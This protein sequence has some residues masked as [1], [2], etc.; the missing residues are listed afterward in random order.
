MGSL[1]SKVIFRIMLISISIYSCIGMQL[2]AQISEDILIQNFEQ[3]IAHNPEEH[4]FIHT[5]SDIYS[6]GSL[7][8]FQ[9]YLYNY[10]DASINSDSLFLWLV[11]FK[12]ELIEKY[13]FPIHQGTAAGEIS[14]SHSV[15][16]GEYFL[17][18]FTDAT[19]RSVKPELLSHKILVRDFKI[20]PV[21][22]KLTNLK[23]EYSVGD[24]AELEIIL[25]DSKGKAIKHDII[26]YSLSK[27]GT[28]F[29]YGELT[30]DRHG[31]AILSF[32]IPEE[33]GL[34]NIAAQISASYNG[35]IHTNSILIPTI[36]RSILMSFYPEGGKLVEGFESKMVFTAQNV[37]GE[38][39]D[40]EGILIDDDEQ[41]VGIIKTSIPGLGYFS[42]LPDVGNP[43]IMRLTSPVT[44]DF[45]FDFPAIHEEGIQLKMLNISKEE[46]EIVVNSNYEN[47]KIAIMALAEMN[48]GIVWT[49]SAMLEDSLHFI[50]PLSNLPDGI[51]RVNIL[52]QDYKLYAQR[53]LL[54]SKHSGRIDAEM[55]IPERNLLKKGKLILD[56]KSSDNQANKGRVSVSVVD[57]NF[58]PDWSPNP[59]IYTRFLLGPSADNTIF[60]KDYFL[61]REDY[62]PGLFDL[63]MITQIDT[64]YDWQKIGLGNYG[65]ENISPTIFLQRILDNEKGSPM[66]Q[67][68]SI[69]RVDQ[70]NERYLFRDQ[71]AF[72]DFLKVNN[73]KL[74]ERKLTYSQLSKEEKVMKLIA[75]GTP[76][77]SVLRVL[78][79]VIINGGSI[80][81][82]A[83]TSINYNPPALIIVDGVPKGSQSKI[84]KDLNPL[85]VYNMKVYTSVSDILKYT[86]T[87]NS[88]G[89][90]VVTTK[91]AAQALGMMTDKVQKPHDPCLFW[92]PDIELNSGLRIS[93]LIPYPTFKS[94][95]RLVIQGLDESGKP[96]FSSF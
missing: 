53:P 71:P 79:P 44:E 59:D 66:T 9:A 35:F 75:R 38:A 82:R 31:R 42:L 13:S 58:C 11:N 24:K 45:E 15:Q 61:N 74:R 47:E 72:N 46:L 80:Y 40:V 39:I 57:N 12:G 4:V 41:E 56:M 48:G 95:Y 83:P 17:K 16:Y 94:K 49:H 8:R 27:N 29:D 86:G 92:K 20:P 91:T 50:I 89:I 26:N 68:A 10:Q 54:I 63:F 76:L 93:L 55:E 19:F 67:F 78:K 43:V 77:L 85:S 84:L 73:F 60:P 52:D 3:F 37:L 70:F 32:P 51:M 34:S 21:R 88:C 6:P 90:I 22:I 18:A 25:S 81:F 33:Q 5:D 96:L 7:I 28:L 36:H 1:F 2:Q 14:L 87:G 69:L 62:D 23:E 64:K 30:S 65:S